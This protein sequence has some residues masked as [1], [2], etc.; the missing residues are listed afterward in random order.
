MSFIER[1][2][3]A[4]SQAAEQARLAAEQAR[5]T[6][7]ETGE[8]VSATI[9]DPSTAEKARE[10]LGRARRGISTAI[11]RIDPSVL[12]DVI[13]KAT[14]LQEKANAA[15]KEKGSPYRI[16]EISIGAAIP[17]SVSFGI[18]R[19]DDPEAEVLPEVGVASSELVAQLGSGEETVLALDG[20]TVEVP[21]QAVAD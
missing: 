2:K 19:V 9:S 11:D 3:Q 7:T 5:Q 4:A 12:A 13:I 6:A 10:A 1:A 20:S 16:G 21:A 18:S 8:R 17:P 14:A 15:L